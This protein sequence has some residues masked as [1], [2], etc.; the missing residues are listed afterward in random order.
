MLI[1]GVLDLDNIDIIS[2]LGWLSLKFLLMTIN[3]SSV[4]PVLMYRREQRRTW[5]ALLQVRLWG[6]VV[7]GED[8]V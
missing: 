6:G 7:P 3:E 4:G 8:V 1:A 5:A 2:N